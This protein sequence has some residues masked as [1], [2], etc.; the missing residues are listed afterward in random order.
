MAIRAIVILVLCFFSNNIL[1]QQN[2]P[3]SS[4]EILH[5]L[6]KFEVTGRALYLAAHPDDE[7]TRLITYLANE[8]KVSTAYLSLT[9]GD[10]G[11][12]LIG[13]EQSSLL[14]VIRTQELLEARKIDGG[15]QYFTRAV[16]F[17]YSKSP[18]ETLELWDRNEVLSDVVW[19]IRK[20]QPDIIINRFPPDNK[21][22]HGHHSASAILAAEAFHLAADSTSFPDQLK[23]V[24]V[25][26]PSR[27][28]FNSSSWWIKNLAELADT[29]SDYIKVDVG[30]YNALLGKWYTELAAE[31]RSMHKSQGFGSARL[32]GSTTEYLQHVT[33]D[34]VENNLWEGIDITWNRIPGAAA[35]ESLIS[36]AIASYNF[37]NPAE[38]V[39]RLIEIYSEVEKLDFP[40]KS[41]RL[42]DLKG[43]IK[44]ALGL[45]LEAISKEAKTTPGK[46]IE[47]QIMA[48]NQSDR[49]LV[50]K[51]L[52]A[53]NID[54]TLNKTLGRNKTHAI[55]LQIKIPENTNF[56]QPYWLASDYST[57]FDVSDQEEIG[58][59][60]NNAALQAV[61]TLEIEGK[62]F[63]FF[64]NIE[65]R[66]V[67]RVEGEKQKPI[68]ISPPITINLDK[69]VYLSVN[70][71]SNEIK[72]LVK[73]HF[74]QTDAEVELQL[75]DSWKVSPKSSKVSFEKIGEIQE[76]IFEVSPG[77]KAMNGSINAQVKVGN[78]VYNQSEILIDHKHIDQQVLFPK[79]SAPISSFNLESDVQKV[80]YFMGAGDKVPDALKLLNID[81]DLLE[82]AK[83]PTYKLS[84]YDCI[85]LGIR[86]LNS[87]KILAEYYLFLL[88]YVKDG[89][90]LI[91]QY[92]TNRDIIVDGVG[93]FPLSISRDRVT[94]EQA[95]ATM[96]LPEHTALNYPNKIDNSDFDNWVQERGLYFGGERDDAYQALISWNDPGES[97]KDGALLVANYG[98]GVFVYTGISFFRQLPAGV[99]GAY[100]IFVNLIN[101]KQSKS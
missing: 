75:P 13:T 53:S 81:V 88:D 69:P 84:D 41:E 47:L 98:K 6:K 56:T 15:K 46:E 22:G 20:F 51:Q 96:L 68:S 12:N 48:L 57:M 26:Q 86:A 34:K 77:K 14:G 61:F 71:A 82:S 62:T 54:S 93:P 27:M 31:S 58:K 39:P 91:V 25:W 44:G 89:G 4:G 32:K 24:D 40:Q 79:A 70:G 52:S 95:K 67:D 80:A 36:K 43:I 101:L 87:D 92:L 65:Y 50:F 42:E 99:P 100:R 49:K 33:G 97:P 23:Y 60:Q 30:K 17:G 11:Q 16:D 5:A 64:E 73:N 1:A 28:Y 45:H 35:I 78:A 8:D 29:S 63:E 55:S 74:G 37:E 90:T 59:A 19:V 9:R 94:V 83:I 72:V 10:G 21:A 38:I 2:V 66:W 76:I 3:R 85:V 7:N 18:D